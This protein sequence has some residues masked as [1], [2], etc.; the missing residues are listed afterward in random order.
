MNIDVLIVILLFLVLI[1]SI[2]FFVTYKYLK[3]EE[4]DRL[5]FIYSEIETEKKISKQLKHLPEE[6]KALQKGTHQKVQMIKI[7]VLDIDF[8]LSEIF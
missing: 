4:S 5:K 2:Y 6:I 7:G 8:T 3:I 1:I